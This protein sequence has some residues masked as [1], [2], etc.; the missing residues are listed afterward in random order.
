MPNQEHV[1][2]CFSVPAAEQLESQG[3]ATHIWICNYAVNDQSLLNDLRNSYEVT[4]FEGSEDDL[5]GSLLNIIP[6]VVEHHPS[7][8]ITFF[9]KDVIGSLYR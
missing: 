3:D 6:T 2:V 5:L 8:Q 9:G 7:G 4:T 1:L